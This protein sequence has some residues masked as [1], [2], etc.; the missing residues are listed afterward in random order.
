MV[1]TTDRDQPLFINNLYY[2]PIDNITMTTQPLAEPNIVEQLQ[3]PVLTTTESLLNND[4]VIHWNISSTIHDHCCEAHKKGN[5]HC[6]KGDKDQDFTGGCHHWE[7]DSRPRM[8]RRKGQD[9]RGEG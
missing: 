6:P 3:T 2:P 5:I 4:E 7:E 8:K 1:L 9:H